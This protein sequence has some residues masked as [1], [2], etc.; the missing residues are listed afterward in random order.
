MSGF[1]SSYQRIPILLPQVESGPGLVS[2]L[3][4][5]PSL[6]LQLSFEHMTAPSHELVSHARLHRLRGNVVEIVEL[7]DDLKG[8]API[9]HVATDDLGVE[10]LG[11][12]VR[13]RL[14]Q[15]HNGVAKEEVGSTHQLVERI[16]MAPRALD[17]FK[18][19]ADLADSVDK[20]VGRFRR[21][22]IL[23]IDCFTL[24]VA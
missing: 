2:R 18:S 11:E 6:F 5:R 9:E 15:G 17:T 4:V 12:L 19:L 7:L 13:T 10:P 21:T 24:V 22:P 23:R 16:E 20:L 14:A 8:P 1:L 3:I